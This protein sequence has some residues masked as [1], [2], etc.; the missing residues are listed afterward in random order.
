M[1]NNYLRGFIQEY[2]MQEGV[3]RIKAEEAWGATDFRHVLAKLM[4][5]LTIYFIVEE[6]G[7]EVYVTNDADGKYFPDQFYLDA[8][9][10]GNYESEGLWLKGSL[11][12]S[13]E[14]CGC[15]AVSPA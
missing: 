4:P 13:R 14:H 12:W 11:S 9:I 3:I 1:K 6:P 7:C 15:T 10:N 2:E 8:C 5:E